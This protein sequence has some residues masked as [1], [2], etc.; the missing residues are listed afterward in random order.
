MI[1]VDFKW[2]VKIRNS[3]TFSVKS[4][5]INILDFVGH[6]LS[7]TTTQLY[8]CSVRAAVD[9]LLTVGMAVFQ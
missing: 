1:N 4:Q 2:L 5:K 3:Q 9:N 7:V 8:L 6:M